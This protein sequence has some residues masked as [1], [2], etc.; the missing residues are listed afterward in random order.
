MTEPQTSEA[1]AI[2]LVAKTQQPRP[3]SARPAG[4]PAVPLAAGIANVGTIATSTLYYAAG[5]AG[6]MAGAGGVL[7]V[8]VASVVAAGAGNRR[9]TGSVF[10]STPGRGHV[11]RQRSAGGTPARVGRLG[12]LMRS[13]ALGRAAAV[14]R[15]TAAGRTA[16]PRPVGRHAATATPR[17][18]RATPAGKTPAAAGIRRALSRLGTGTKAAATAPVRAGRA[19]RKGL[20]E[21]ASPGLAASTARKAVTSGRRPTTRLGRVMRTVGGLAVGGLAGTLAA[22]RNAKRT[23]FPGRPAPT[24]QTGRVRNGVR[25]PGT[26]V[27]GRRSHNPVPAPRPAPVRGTTNPTISTGGVPVSFLF[28]DSAAEILA[29]AARYN[30][31]DMPQFGRDISQIGEAVRNVANAIRVIVQRGQAEYPVNPKIMELLAAGYQQIHGAANALDEVG[32]AFRALHE[33]DLQRHEQPRPNEH[34]WNVGR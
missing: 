21:A 26:A 23:V 31:E 1:P 33:H 10:R 12:A 27:G 25:R 13:P 19:V 24:G 3:P 18:G 30:P 32:P 2:T 6:L 9:R 17:A 7:A 14:G 34:L 28:A 16:A 4:L 20:R 8:G 5:T 22:L 29:Q 15:S 11:P